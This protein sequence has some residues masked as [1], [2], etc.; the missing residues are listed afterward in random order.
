MS[1]T[2]T[3]GNT[4]EDAFLLSGHKGAVL[5][6]RFGPDGDI[7][8]TG[9]MDRTV[10]LWKLPKSSEEENLN[11]GV[12]EGHKGAVTCL[13]FVSEGRLFTGSSDTNVTFWD[14]ESGIKVRNGKTHTDCINDCSVS[15]NVALS[16][17]D[18]G[19]GRIW[20][21]R[22]KNE[23]LK[24]STDYPLL[25]CHLTERHAYV[26]GIDPQ[27]RCYDIRTGKELWSDGGMNESTVSLAVN[28]NKSL[29]LARS[30]DGQ[31]R[32]LKTSTTVPS[33]IP[34]VSQSGYSGLKASSD[35][36]P[37]ADFLHDDVFVALGNEDGK[38][39][40]WS[41]ANRRMVSMFEGHKKAVTDLC[42]H[43]LQKIL[44]SAS[45]DGGVI[46]RRY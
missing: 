26:G 39:I 3:N 2:T 11:Y 9:G 21:E 24:I 45:V 4:P 36:L 32:T 14:I 22:E 33:G 12:L 27:I 28:T 42:F 6:S 35:Y 29:L 43:P 40:L 44:M 34:R 41:T 31:L 16:V 5:A 46:V 38:V 23:V 25:A 13:D 19:S 30:M 1:L 37:R 17:G 18:D 8:A 10:C 20:D 7:L 15:H